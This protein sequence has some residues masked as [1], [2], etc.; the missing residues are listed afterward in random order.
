MKYEYFLKMFQWY[1]IAIFLIMFDVIAQFT[2]LALLHKMHHH[3]ATSTRDM[4]VRIHLFIVN[5]QHT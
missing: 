5:A 3:E 1:K 4:L 2:C